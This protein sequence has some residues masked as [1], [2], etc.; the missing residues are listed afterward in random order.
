MMKTFSGL[1]ALFVATLTGGAAPITA[2]RWQPVDF[3][4]KSAAEH[5]N[6]FLVRFEAEG[7]GHGGPRAAQTQPLSG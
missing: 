6:P 4:F 3:A 7:T 5:P 2:S 1:L